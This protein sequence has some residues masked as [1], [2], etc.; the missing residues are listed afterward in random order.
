MFGFMYRYS[1]HTNVNHKLRNIMSISTL[2]IQK[3]EMTESPYYAPGKINDNFDL[4]SKEFGKILTVI[5]YESNVVSTNT[6]ISKPGGDSVVTGRTV[7]TGDKGTVLSVLPGGDGNVSGTVLSIEHDGTLK[8]PAIIIEGNE[9]STIKK[10]VVGTLEVE[11][12]NISGAMDYGAITIGNTPTIIAVNSN[13]VGESASTKLDIS[14][15]SYVLLDCSNNNTQLTPGNTALISVDVNNIKVNQ[16]IK[17]QLYKKNG[18]NVNLGVLNPVANRVFLN[19]STSTGYELV[20]GNPMFDT[21]KGDGFLEVQC[22]E[23]NGSK[24]LLI[25][26]SK[27]VAGL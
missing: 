5:N 15:S 13:N 20:Q 1:I 8:A 24:K 16:I 11:D 22:V 21:S 19:I 25:L 2:K 27:H 6:S 9:K 18:T 17:L 3:I 7:L 14:S 26:N 10:L 4:V 12:I 23:Y